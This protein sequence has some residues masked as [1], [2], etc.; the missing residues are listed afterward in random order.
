MNFQLHNFSMIDI[1]NYCYYA[2]STLHKQFIS[3]C[4]SHLQQAIRCTFSVWISIISNLLNIYKIS[5]YRKECSDIYFVISFTKCKHLI[6]LSVTYHSIPN[7]S[8]KV[9]NWTF[10]QKHLKNSSTSW[11]FEDK[12]RQEKN[13]SLL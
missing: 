11:K 10:S 6:S 12:N 4:E 7:N 13:G 8:H 9:T 3:E 2:Q 1:S 5:H